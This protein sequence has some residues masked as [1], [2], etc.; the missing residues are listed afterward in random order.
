[1]SLT[2]FLKDDSEFRILLDQTFE[3]PTLEIK[4]E[5]VADPQTSNY[6][7][8][9][10]AFDYLLRFK[11]ERMYGVGSRPW[12]ASQGLA[13]AELDGITVESTKKSLATL[14]DDAGRLHREYLETGVMTDELLGATLDLARLDGIYRSG[15]VADDFGQALDGD[16]DDLRRLYEVIPEE[17]FAGAETVIL[18][19]EFGSASKLVGGADGDIVLGSTL[20]D[21]K[22]V[23]EATLKPDYWRQLVGYAVLADIAHDELDHMPAFT[24]VGLYFSRHGVLWR[25]SASRIYQHEKYAKFKSWFQ[26]RAREHFSGASPR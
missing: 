9:G 15:R 24:A 7:L 1:M 22:T 19:P 25:T 21:I 3:K 14:L 26:Q 18:N 17:E 23:K 13:L 12:V 2:S 8:I 11:L 5:R 20:I 10:T 16:I 6:G 4:A